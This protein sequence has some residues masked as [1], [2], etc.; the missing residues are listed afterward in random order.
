MKNIFAAFL[1]LLLVTSCVETVVVGSVATIAVVT[2][3][4]TIRDS[5]EDIAIAVKIDK[6]FLTSGL[7][8]VSNSI[9]VMVDEGRVL[10]TGVVRDVEKGQL[11]HEI[12]WKIK[13]VKEVID[14][15]EISK[16]GVRIHDFSGSVTDSYITAAI[17][18]KLFFK[19]QI[20]PSNYKI[21]TFNRVVYLLGVYKSE[22]DLQEV[23]QIVSKTSGVK[24]VV[25]YVIS[26]NDSRRKS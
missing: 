17:K 6:D 19:P 23:L 7:K 10:L 8:G 15:I 21:T 1:L 5:G 11:A 20:A 26:A 14:E 24:K 3:E 12:I 9:G 2:R 16:E 22:D 4:K 18:I 13:G 25:N